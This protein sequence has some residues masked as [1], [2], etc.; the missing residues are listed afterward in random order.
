MASIYHV[1][2]SVYMFCN[3]FQKIAWEMKMS[4]E[5]NEFYI[6]N[7]LKIVYLEMNSVTSTLT[8]QF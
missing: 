7:K 5:Q 6:K 8:I 2:S 3:C 4:R 1:Y